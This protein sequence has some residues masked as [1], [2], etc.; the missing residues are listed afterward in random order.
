MQRT[1]YQPP[2]QPD[3]RPDGTP[4]VIQLRT[5]RARQVNLNPSQNERTTE[6]MLPKRRRSSK[7]FFFMAAGVVVVFGTMLFWQQAVVPWWIGVQNQWN[8][9]TAHIT[10]LDAD[11]GH[12]GMSHFIAEYTKGEIVIIELSYANPNNYHIYTMNGMLSSQEKPV[13]MLSTARDTHTGRI[14]L[15]IDVQGRGFQTVLYNTGSTFSETA[16]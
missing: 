6:P 5:S 13:V 11:V 7:P 8:Y 15:I 16:P 12:G 1:T 9:G 4:Q 14:D 3:M 10:Q 2:A